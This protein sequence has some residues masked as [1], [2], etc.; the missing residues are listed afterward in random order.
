MPR[1]G[2]QRPRRSHVRGHVGDWGSPAYAGKMLRCYFMG[3]VAR[4]VDPG[5]RHDRHTLAMP[6]F[7]YHFAVWDTYRCL[8][9]TTAVARDPAP[10]ILRESSS[11]RPPER[12][13][14]YWGGSADSISQNERLSQ[15]ETW[16]PQGSKPVRQP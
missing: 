8:K 4:S 1:H 10:Q 11:S 5:L 12:E 7:A 3:F 2:R 9:R 16:L 6:H 13:S 15:S 14:G